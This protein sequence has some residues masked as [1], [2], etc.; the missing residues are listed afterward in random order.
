MQSIY[1]AKLLLVDDNPDLLAL[2]C[3]H[4]G[5]AGY[6]HI[7]TAGSCAS[8]RAAF[9][10]R[11]PELMILDI[12]LSDGDGFALFRQ[13][14]AQADIPALF[15]SA[16]DA[17]AAP[18]C[19]GACPAAEAGGEPGPYRDLRRPVRGGMGRGLLWL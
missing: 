12:N 9:A 10:A 5:G 1:E 11:R 2:L 17:D 18:D 19:H 8:A 15:L 4:L 16:R 3:S 14:R 13:L 6:Q 7:V